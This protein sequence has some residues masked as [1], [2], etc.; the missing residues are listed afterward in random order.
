MRDIPSAIIVTG[1]SRGIGKGLA[2]YF[3]ERQV[4]VYGCSR[5]VSEINHEH[6][7]HFEVDVSDE[8]AVCAM[9]AEVARAEQNTRLGLLNNAGIASMNHLLL[10]PVAT[11]EKLWK[12]NFLGSF[13]FLRELAK[14]MSRRGGGSIVNF[15]TVARPLNLEGEMAYATSKAALESLTRIAAR[16][17]QAFQIAVNAVGPGPTQTDLLR[18]VP[19][20]KMDTLLQSQPV[21]RYTTIEEICHV[22]EFLL[23][24]RSS[25]ITGQVLYFGGVSG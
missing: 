3:L 10:T 8:H 2:E 19:T 25:G 14:V 9:V 21:S 1:T 17:L 23:D 20:G 6:Y 16:E 11:V 12:T 4:R 15:T 13:L 24:A 22:S 5:G 18:G 7:R